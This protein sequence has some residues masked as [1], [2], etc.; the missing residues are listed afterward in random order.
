MRGQAASNKGCGGPAGRG[1][2]QKQ[3][4]NK[5]EAE[6]TAGWTGEESLQR[7]HSAHD[8]RPRWHSLLHRVRQLSFHAGTW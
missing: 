1:E 7:N 6:S 8:A 2:E 5:C 3:R 4:E